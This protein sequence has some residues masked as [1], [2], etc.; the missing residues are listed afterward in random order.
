[1]VAATRLKH[2]ESVNAEE[3]AEL[4][5]LTAKQYWR[6]GAKLVA[7]KL[8]ELAAL[9]YG[10]ELIDVPAGTGVSFLCIRKPSSFVELSSHV[11]RKL[12]ADVCAIDTDVG[13]LEI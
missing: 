2:D 7:S 3:P 9:L 11:T 10:H 1:M 12:E 8:G 4:N 13:A 5:E 6:F